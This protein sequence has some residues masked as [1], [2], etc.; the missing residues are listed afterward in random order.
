MKVTIN[1]PDLTLGAFIG[2]IF[3]GVD[4]MKMA[5][6]ALDT[7]DLVDGNEITIPVVE[8]DGFTKWAKSV[9]DSYRSQLEESK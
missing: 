7:D 6:S 1:F 2:Y 3:T 4:G 8:Q 9:A 5:M